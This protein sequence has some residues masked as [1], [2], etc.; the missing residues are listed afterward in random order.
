MSIGSPSKIVFIVSVVIAVLALVSQVLGLIGGSLNVPFF[1]ANA[2]WTLA[3]AYILLFLGVTV[4]G[5]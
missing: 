4:K 3:G 1:T 5:L 2:Y